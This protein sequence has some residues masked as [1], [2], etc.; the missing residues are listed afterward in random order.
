MSIFKIFFFI[1]NRFVSLIIDTSKTSSHGLI[2]R[3][4]HDDSRISKQ[5]VLLRL[6]LHF[7]RHSSFVRSN[8][9]TGFDGGG[10]RRFALREIEERAG[11]CGRYH[12]RRTQPAHR[13]SSGWQSLSLSL[14]LS[15]FS[16]THVSL[17]L[18]SVIPSDLYRNRNSFRYDITC[19]FRMLFVSIYTSRWCEG[20]GIVIVMSVT[21]LWWSRLLRSIVICRALDPEP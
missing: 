20:D 4:G 12:P 11:S 8:L 19:W 10:K 9:L 6:D 13:C 7:Q 16:R 5:N 15:A 17:E 1:L 3:T 14:S 21:S 2:R 18:R